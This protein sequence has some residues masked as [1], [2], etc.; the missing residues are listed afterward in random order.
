MFRR[1]LF[2]LNTV[3]TV[4][5]IQ[6]IQYNKSIIEDIHGDKDEDRY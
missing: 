2:L 6:L 4:D 3:N 5:L 1:C